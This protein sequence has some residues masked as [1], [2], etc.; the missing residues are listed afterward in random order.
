MADSWLRLLQQEEEEEVD[1]DFAH[2]E[3]GSVGGRGVRG[4]GGT[5][6]FDFESGSGSFGEDAVMLMHQRM[7]SRIASK[8]TLQQSGS[9][10]SL[11]RI[12]SMEEGGGGMIP[13]SSSQSLSELMQRSP[14]PRNTSTDNFLMRDTLSRNVSNVSLTEMVRNYSSASLAA[15]MEQNE[16]W[17][18]EE[19]DAIVHTKMGGGG[20][21]QFL[22]ADNGRSMHH[23]YH[24]PQQQQA[25]TG[26]RMHRT[27][28]HNKLVH[29]A[30][31]AHTAVG[32]GMPR[33]ASFEK[34]SRQC[35][36]QDPSLT[37]D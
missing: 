2:S 25:S 9:S 23:A 26:K 17:G 14:L 33:P 8:S 20:D 21:F 10:E 1:G 36:D 37:N 32:R 3:S 15:V 31:S 4:R 28:S 30:V 7:G 16:T 6:M 5:P 22:Q 19:A 12:M 24:Q 29:E 34:L 18:N 27:H 11:N 13:S 35:P